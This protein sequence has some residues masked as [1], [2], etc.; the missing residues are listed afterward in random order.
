VHW[1]LHLENCHQAFQNFLLAEPR[2]ESLSILGSGLLL[3]TPLHLIPESIKE[4]NLVDVVHTKD[5]RRSVQKIASERGFRFQVNWIEADLLG[6]ELKVR[7]DLVV[8]ANLL[9]QL[10]LQGI[11]TTSLS[12]SEIQR[13]H[14]Q[15]IRDCAPARLLFSDYQMNVRNLR[16]EVIE[17]QKTVENPVDWQKK[18]TWNLAPAP[19]IAKDISVTLDMGLVQELN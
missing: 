6:Q 17:T 18:W 15:K 1:G 2:A 13:Q 8:S 19:E 3:E 14:W 5:V 16:G 11:A 7:T 12:A 9:S 10:P 4:L